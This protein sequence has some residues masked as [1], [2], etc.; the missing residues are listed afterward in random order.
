M[1][2]DCSS[3]LTG[4]WNRMARKRSRDPEEQRSEPK[5]PSGPWTALAVPRYN[6]ARKR[7]SPAVKKRTNEVQSQIVQDP[8]RRERKKGALHNVWVEK[9]QAENDQYL[10]AYTI[11]D[12]KRT[13]TFY[14]IGQHENF[15]RDLTKYIRKVVQEFE[16]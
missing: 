10:L 8:H 9:F 5:A 15:Y 13:V 16:R 14:D 11:D 7:F 3:L 6:K 1:R 2:Q 4:A 12:A